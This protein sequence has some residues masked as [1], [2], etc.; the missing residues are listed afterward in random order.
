MRI[1]FFRTRPCSTGL[2]LI[3]RHR[4][5]YL[6][7]CSFFGLQLLSAQQVRIAGGGEEGERFR[8]DIPLHARHAVFDSFVSRIARIPFVRFCQF[9]SFENGLTRYVQRYTIV[10]GTKFNRV[11]DFQPNCRPAYLL[12]TPRRRLKRITL[13]RA[14]ARLARRIP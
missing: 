13:S 1:Q 3:E 7:M 8:N 9:S 2:R 10:R 11:H 12:N 4:R 6:T 5:R 14:G